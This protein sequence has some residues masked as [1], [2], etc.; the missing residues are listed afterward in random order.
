[1]KGKKDMEEERNYLVREDIEK[2]FRSNNESMTKE[3]VDR[4]MNEVF[5]IEKTDGKIYFDNFY[6]VMK[7][8]VSPKNLKL[9]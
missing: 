5:E 7:D 2:L 1:M 8:V 4:L 3:E 6:R 9:F